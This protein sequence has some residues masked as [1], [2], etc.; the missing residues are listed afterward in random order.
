MRTHNICILPGDGIGPEVI[1]EA[2]RVLNAL[3]ESSTSDN[4]DEN[5][6]NFNFTYGDI[7][8]GAYEKHGNPL[9]EETIAKVEAADATLFGAVT[10]PPNIPNYSSPILGLRKHFDLYAN[11]RPFISRP[12][13]IKWY[14]RW[15][16]Y[17]CY[18]RKYRRFVFK[19]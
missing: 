1:A 4:S 14:T 17:N 9:P 3:T 2:V 12:R 7:G 18:Q 10:T 15:I 16:K 8:F 19:S 5:T 13:I 6:L 11:V